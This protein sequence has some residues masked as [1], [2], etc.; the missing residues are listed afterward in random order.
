MID[1]PS[2]LYHGS[3]KKINGPLL[4]ILLENN[5]SDY[6]HTRPAVFATEKADIAAMF[7]FPANLISSICFE[8]D[9]AFICIWG[10]AKEFDEKKV[11]GFLYIF[12]SESFE[13]VGKEYEWQSFNAVTPVEIKEYQSVIDGMIEQGVQVYFIND[14]TIFDQIVENKNNRAPI[15]SKLASENQR[16]NINIKKFS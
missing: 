7:M 8:Q 4:P 15:V 1:K 3:S 10:T 16:R 2:K 12:S 11:E 5:S 14:D 13:K 6:T 9:I